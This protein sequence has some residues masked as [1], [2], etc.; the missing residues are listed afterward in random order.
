MSDRPQ[1]ES[2]VIQL[3]NVVAKIKEELYRKV[4]SMSWEIEFWN[5]AWHLYR[6]DLQ[7]VRE[8]N[9]HEPVIQ[10]RQIYICLL[11]KKDMLNPRAVAEK[12]N[13]ER[14]T[15]ITTVQTVQGYV[16]IKDQKFM[17]IYKHFKHLFK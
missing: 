10:V 8:K 16:K 12:V 4:G 15:M 2:L 13:R 1:I 5:I 17:N 7:K 14:S 6:I 3:D 11:I 9:K